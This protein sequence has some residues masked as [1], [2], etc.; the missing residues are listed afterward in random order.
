MTDIEAALR[1]EVFARSRFT[2][3]YCHIPLALDNSP[4]CIDHIIA[5]K[6]HGPTTTDNLAASCFHDNS[7][8]GTDLT[9]I[10]PDTGALTRLF[11]PRRDV[12]TEHFAWDGAEIVGLTAIGRTTIYVLN[13]NDPVRVMTRRLLVASGDMQCS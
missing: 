8:K 7:S 12:W 4:A 3:E 10:D 6:H 2:C 13:V 9:G 11:H 5:R 1:R